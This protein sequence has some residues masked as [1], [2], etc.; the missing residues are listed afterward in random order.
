M[1][2]PNVQIQNLMRQ[3]IR[4]RDGKNGGN[5]YEMVKSLM[6]P[7]N[8]NELIYENIKNSFVLPQTLQTSYL[9]NFKS[10]FE[11][12]L[13]KISNEDKEDNNQDNIFEFDDNNGNDDNDDDDIN[14]YNILI[15]DQSNEYF[16]YIGNGI[17]NNIYK[18]ELVDSKWILYS[19]IISKIYKSFK[20]NMLNENIKIQSFHI[21]YD[22]GSVQCALNHLFNASKPFSEV[23]VLWKWV[24]LSR[25]NQLYKKYKENFIPLITSKSYWDQAI[26]VSNKA[27]ELSDR[28]NLIIYQISDITDLDP[29]KMRK[30]YLFT[31]I[32]ALRFLDCQGI[33]LM[34]FPPEKKWK[35]LEINILALCGLIFDAVYFTKYTIKNE[36][37]VLICRDKK[38]N[39]STTALI[40]KLIKILN[41]SETLC[42][43]DKQFLNEEFLSQ[44]YYLQKYPLIPIL[45]KQ[46]I[47]EL[48]DILDI[49]EKLIY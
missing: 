22:S 7:S 15:E 19:F 47:D 13:D 46:I 20:T 36:Y 45:F 18:A 38:K 21:G 4:E 9:Y 31:I 37:C 34:E 25:S 24:T 3:Y 30:E 29:L 42:I 48:K 40:K 11:Y 41:E 2:S 35:L 26:F 10:T 27:A 43:V 16:Q 5:L 8:S 17:F 14:Y 12:S 33:L 6:S 28:Y 1:T 39:L 23:S 32:M 49:N 44:I